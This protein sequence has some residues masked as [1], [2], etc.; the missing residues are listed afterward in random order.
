MELRRRPS[1]V[2]VGVPPRSSLVL[3]VV[4]VTLLPFLGGCAPRGS[5]FH[6]LSVPPGS[7][8]LAQ[9]TQFVPRAKVLEAEFVVRSLQASGV[10]VAD[11]D[12]ESIAGGRVECCGGSNEQDTARFFYVPKSIKVQVGDVVEIRSGCAG[13]LG[14]PCG[15][16]NMLTRVREKQNDFGSQCRWD[17]PG[18]DLRERILYC[19]WMRQEGWTLE[20]DGLS[21]YWVKVSR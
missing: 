3:V 17:P 11:I 1:R 9:V 21:K 5:R 12:D 6:D 14:N 16:V 2:L 13:D 18:P 15:P 8:R 4:C 19:N 7:L 10:S 20:K